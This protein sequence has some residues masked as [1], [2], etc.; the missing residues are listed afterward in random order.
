MNIIGKTIPLKPKYLFCVNIVVST[1]FVA[2]AETSGV[3]ISQ[4]GIW[5]TIG[6]A[7]DERNTFFAMAIMLAVSFVMT[8][9]V[10]LYIIC[11]FRWRVMDLI[12][13]K[14]KSFN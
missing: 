7:T 9:G 11:S 3:F 12:M 6:N 8:T 2:V 14:A 1:I 10:E 5:G 13:I 4:M